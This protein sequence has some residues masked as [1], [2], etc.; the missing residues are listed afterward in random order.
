VPATCSP[1][2]HPKPLKV[3]IVA[4]ATR[5]GATQCAFMMRSHDDEQ[6]SVGGAVLVPE[7]LPSTLEDDA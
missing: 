4:G 1:D 5:A 2:Q 6:F 3:G 7:L